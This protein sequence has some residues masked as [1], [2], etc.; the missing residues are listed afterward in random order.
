MSTLE[1]VA[2]VTGLL[3]VM[4]AFWCLVVLALSYISGWQALAASYA[5]QEPPRGTRFAGQSGSV[6]AV[7]YRGSLTVHVASDG[8]FLSTPFIFRIG[9]KPLFIPWTAIKNQKP[10]KFLWHEAIRFEL[11]SAPARELRL[12]PGIFRERTEARSST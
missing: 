3:I 4:P 9:H 10:V 6:G 1:I 8:L 5:A 7:S 2:L 12:P 11:G